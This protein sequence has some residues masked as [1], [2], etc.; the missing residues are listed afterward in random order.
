MVSPT[1]EGDLAELL[2][3]MEMGRVGTGRGI[4]PLWTTAMIHPVEEESGG[5]TLVGG[6]PTRD[7]TDLCHGPSCSQSLPADSATPNEECSIFPPRFKQNPLA[8]LVAPLFT[9][10]PDGSF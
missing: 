6:L 9:A 7:A 4:H 10:Q 1:L 3:R 2:P 5:G 8:S